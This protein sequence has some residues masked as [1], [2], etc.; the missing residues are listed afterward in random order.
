MNKIRWGVL[1]TAKIAREKVI[2][3]MQKGSHSSIDAIA[4]RNAEHAATVAASLG[5][6]K[7]YGS[8]EALLNDADID[9]VYIPLPNHMHVPWAIKALEAN[10]HV[11][12]EK[13]IGLSSE[14]AKQLQQAAS[15]KPQLKIMEAFMYRFH[16]QWQHAKKLAHNGSIGRL[17]TIQSFFSYFNDDADNIRNQQGIGGGGL[18]D[19]GCYGISL[20]R[21]IFDEEPG[22]VAGM[23]EFDPVLKTDRMASGI[24]NFSNGTSSFTCST[25]LVSYQRVNIFGTEGRI[26]IE[27][28]FNAPSLE[29]TKIWLHTDK[30]TEEINFDAV[31]QYTIQGDL[32]SK[33]IIDNTSVPTDLEDAICNMKVIEA[34]FKSSEEGRVINLA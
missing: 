25:Q 34:V 14:E 17:K 23:V 24:L 3:A 13:P 27:I 9:A 11:L 20:S 32:L 7:A 26:E 28:P 19:I 30:G 18:M 5:I 4:S 12:C 22:S 8:Y 31:D 1:S 6:P 33:A 15:Q 2:P 21:F 29:P 10:K 16:P